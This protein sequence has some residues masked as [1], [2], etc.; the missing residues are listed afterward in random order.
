MD[1]REEYGLVLDFLP[2]GKATDRERRAVA[3]VIGEK[4]FTMLEVILKENVTLSIQQRVYIG[5]DDRKE[6]EKIKGRVSYEELTSAA[7]SELERTVR[8]IVEERQEDFVRFFNK[9]GSISIRLHQLEL[10]PGI[11]KKH[12]R[13]LLEQREEKP[14]ESFEDLQKRVALMPDPANVLTARISDELQ[15]KSQHYIFVRPPFRK[16]QF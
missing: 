5:K 13:E 8:K 9:C 10:L 7:R 16:E 1:E 3:Q 11:G 14:F 2:Q 4:Y 15:G 6:I 12:M